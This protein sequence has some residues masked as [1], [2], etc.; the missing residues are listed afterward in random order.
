MFPEGNNGEMEFLVNSAAL[1]PVVCV[2]SPPQHAGVGFTLVDFGFMSH[3]SMDAVGA[4]RPCPSSGLALSPALSH[5]QATELI[6]L[7]GLTSPDS[8]SPN[9]RPL[10][11]S[12]SQATNDQKPAGKD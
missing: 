4:T 6:N 1:F 3:S 10:S 7:L 12:I 2:S 11:Q 8:A 5:W 9:S